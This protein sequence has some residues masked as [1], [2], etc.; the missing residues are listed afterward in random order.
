MRVCWLIWGFWLLANRVS[1]PGELFA[2]SRPLTPVILVSVDTLRADHLGCYGYKGLQTPNIDELTKG[3]TLFSQVSSQ[4]PLTL[5]SHASMLT[6]TQPFSNGIED[7]GTPLTPGAVTLASA[8]KARGYRTAAFVGGFVLDRRFGL[9]QGFDVYD[10]PFN[11]RRQGRS[12][13]SD[14][15]RPGGEVV[16]ETVNW[17]DANGQGPFFIFLHLYDVHAPYELPPPYKLRPFPAGYDDALAYEDKVLGRFSSYLKYQGL[18]EQCLIV[19]TSDHGE[20]LWEHGESTHGYFIYQSTLRVPLIIHWPTCAQKFLPHADDPV[21]LLDVAPTI[22]QFLSIPRPVEFQGRGLADVLSGKSAGDP[23]E[24]YSESVYARN[25]FGCSSLKSLRLGQFKYV[26]APK[27]EF[28]DLSK[29]PAEQHN[30]YLQQQSVALSYRQRLRALSSRF[31]TS[32][33]AKMQALSPEVATALNSLGYVAVSSVNASKVESGADPKDRITDFETNRRAIDLS[34]SGRLTE[35]DTLLERLSSKYPDIPDLR[36]SLAVNQRRMGEK[37]EAIENFR[38]VLKLDPLNVRAHF[39]L[40]VSHYEMGQLEEAQKEL[41]ATLAIAP[42]YNRAA[43]LLGAVLLQEGNTA[44]AYSHFKKMLAVDADNYVANYQLGTLAAQEGKWDE[45]EHYLTAAVKADPG[46]AEAY[47]GLGVVYLMSGKLEK[48][49]S[50]LTEAIRLEP[51]L[52]ETHF[53]LGLVYRQ[54]NKTDE[55]AREF[56]SALAADPQ[57]RKAREALSSPE[58]QPK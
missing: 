20:S 5:P 56:R 31:Q 58:F 50:T 43:E 8:L 28:Y 54:Q 26:D 15:K 51:K 47:N 38:K 27:P 55:A 29:D 18:F 22:L 4:V 12:D 19:F 23:K 24:I 1:V 32:P 53:N 3:G 16:Q 13:P 30:L 46:S 25:H 45:G 39:D 41:Q 40:A 42:Y 33:A 10:S 36:I 37:R 44:G 48:A 52:A 14:V 2:Q 11:L 34:S 21:S 6:S 7:N 9:G 35:A 57:F 49:R 17:L